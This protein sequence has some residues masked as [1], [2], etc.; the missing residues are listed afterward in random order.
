MVVKMERNPNKQSILKDWKASVGNE[1][2]FEKVSM[3]KT[4]MLEKVD[5]KEGENWTVSCAI[6]PM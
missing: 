6:C 5:K 1:N 2:E 4:E 3:E